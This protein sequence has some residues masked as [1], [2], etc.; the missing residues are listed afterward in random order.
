MAIVYLR[1]TAAEIEADRRADMERDAWGE[2]RY[3]EYRAEWD[4][5]LNRLREQ[6]YAVW[7]ESGNADLITRLEAVARRLSEG[8]AVIARCKPCARYEPPTKLPF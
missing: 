7:R 3:R 8:D 5:H 2:Q 4:A 6:R 1:P